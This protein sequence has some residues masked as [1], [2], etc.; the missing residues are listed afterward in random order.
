[1]LQR[2]GTMTSPRKITQLILC[3]CAV[4]FLS[5]CIKHLEP[6]IILY[7]T[8]HDNFAR[9]DTDVQ[10]VQIHYR[11]YPGAG[12]NIVLIHGF[13]SSTYTWKEMVT[14]L[15]G[16]FK[17]SGKPCPRIWTVDMKRLWGRCYLRCK[18][19]D[20]VAKSSVIE[21]CHARLDVP[22]AF[23]DIIFRRIDTSNI[24]RDT[25]DKARFFERL[26][27]NVQE[28]KCSV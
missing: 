7:P 20:S 3:L 21:P 15:Q 26:G 27:Q 23:H 14:E 6:G 25:K 24:F 17:N 2:E 19:F 8:P 1:M 28:A 13:A 9:I 10:D 12:R 5:A 4:C 16:K 18:S 22:G 11:E